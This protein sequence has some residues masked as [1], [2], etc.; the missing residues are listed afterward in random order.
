MC[1]GCVHCSLEHIFESFGSVIRGGNA[2]WRMVPTDN[3]ED[4]IIF[5]KSAIDRGLFRSTSLKK[6]ISIIQKNQSTS[7]DDVFMKPDETKVTGMRHGSYDKLNFKGYVPEETTIYNGDI[8]LGKVSPI[9]P[10]GNSNKTYKDSSEVYKSHAPG[11]VDKVYTDIQN[12]EGYDMRKM[13]IRSERVPMI[14]DKFCSLYGQKG[15]VGITLKH[16]DMP[17]TKNGITPDII[18]NPNC[19]VGSTLVTSSYGLSKRIDSFCSDGLEEVLTWNGNEFVTSFSLGLENKGVRETMT[20][21]LSDGRTLVCTPEHKFKVYNQNEDTYEYK[22]ARLLHTQNDPQADKLLMG[23]EGTED[24]KCIK[25][26]GWVLT[27]GNVRFGYNT[28]MMRINTHLLANTM[29]Y[30]F[31]DNWNTELVQFV[32]S[33]GLRRVEIENITQKQYIK[34]LMLAN[35]TPTSF[36][37]EFIAGYFSS[38]GIAPEVNT[39]TYTS[40]N[41]V[42]AHI[43]DHSKRSIIMDILSVLGVEYELINQETITINNNTQYFN[44][45]GFRH[46]YMKSSKMFACVLFE[47]QGIYSN[48]LDYLDYIECRDVMENGFK[49]YYMAIESKYINP[50]PEMVYDIG[51]AEHHNFI[52]DG[53]CVSNCIPSRMTIAQLIETL[54]GKTCAIQAREGDGTPFVD[55]DI[56]AIKTELEGLGYNRN[57]T[58]YLYNGMTGLRFKAE[59]FIGPTYYHRLKHLVLDKIHARARGPRTL[60][61][62]APPEGRARDGGLRLG[63]M[64]RDSLLAHGTSKLLKE[65]LVDTADAYTTYVCDECGLFA[66]RVFKKE[67]TH[68]ATER[69]VYFCAGC[70]NYSKISKVMIPYAF[71]LLCQELA[72]MNVAP[73]I[74]T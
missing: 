46:E 45:I 58:E 54:M 12:H 50:E 57:G 28:P 74:K 15:T 72:A 40:F 21:R 26:S 52:A 9:Q 17:F 59:I 6:A 2:T 35:S 70:K 10:I 19:F 1:R 56:E 62:R 32:R 37:R 39:E 36:V 23:M 64:E 22:E 61:T 29:G 20:V 60:L 43:S 53:V 7:Q 18:I 34:N 14:G 25:E 69:D 65:K 51:V 33:L 66:Q 8:I 31:S 48:V 38:I 73:R 55:T 27:V 13:R 11:V 63:E 68:H 49:K 5:N 16:S 30:I 24:V 41:K 3:Q 67:S 44:K 4:S 71:K 42:Q 47:R